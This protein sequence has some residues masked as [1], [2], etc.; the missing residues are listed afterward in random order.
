[1]TDEDGKQGV[2]LRLH[3]LGAPAIVMALLLALAGVTPAGAQSAA[4]VR[5]STLDETSA[6]P[7]GISGGLKYAQSFCTGDFDVTLSKVRLATRTR[8]ELEPAVTI[9]ADT[10]GRPGGTID[11][12]T[13]PATFDNDIS[14]NEDFT[15]S[16]VELDANTRYWLVIYAGQRTPSLYVDI[17]RSKLESSAEAG[18]SIGDKMLYQGRSGWSP[19]FASSE[20]SGFRM[21]MGV[22]AMGP[23]PSM[24]PPVFSDRDCN[25]D[26]DPL[27]LRVDENSAAGAVV[28]QAAAA[29]PDDD[30]LTHSVSGADA[31][32]FNQVF[33]MNASTGEITVKS[34][35]SPNYE[36][37]RSYSI[38]VSVT[39]GED[40]SG[41]AESPALTDDSVSVTIRVNNIDEAGTITLIPPTPAVGS[42]LDAV[43]TDP[44]GELR[45][46][47][48]RWY[49]AD[50][51]TG[52]F[53]LIGGNN[54]RCSAQGCYA[55]SAADQGKF[56]K[57]EITYYDGASTPR[58]ASGNLII[59]SSNL[60]EGRRIVEAA[61]SDA[62]AIGGL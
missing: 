54:G 1:M 26:A 45:I 25:G 5:V 56:L 24:A 32:G 23:A 48:V 10:S 9:S 3:R 51:A 19:A 18:W 8:G 43:L 15:S 4:T 40:A 62:V 6:N 22:Y 28:G 37:K 30:S 34:G 46:I 11:T 59:V 21:R 7:V 14:T 20:P 31:A 16:G 47:W 41:N 57:I 60:A 33:S 55:P 27:T 53:T 58:S 38:T 52:P 42:V 61:Y 44:D 12:L 35:A 29:D 2:R 17:T 50:T 36:V 39:D 49:R 13:N